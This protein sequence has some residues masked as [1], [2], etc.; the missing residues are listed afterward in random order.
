MYGM[1]MKGMK[2]AK[3]KGG[4]KTSKARMMAGTNTSAPTPP[5]PP[6]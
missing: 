3:K 2:M 5:Y 1:K 4:N 6:A